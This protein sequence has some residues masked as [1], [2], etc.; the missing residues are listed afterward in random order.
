MYLGIAV[1]LICSALRSL[2]G[3]TL[4]QGTV[5]ALVSYMT[6]ALLAIG[7]ALNAIITRE[8]AAILWHGGSYYQTSV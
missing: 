7:H 8:S 3:C 5:V 6:S 2:R 1:T 4:L